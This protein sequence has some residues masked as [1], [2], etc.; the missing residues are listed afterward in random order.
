MK[1]VIVREGTKEFGTYGTLYINGLF[2]CYTLEDADRGL[3]N[4]GTKVAGDTAIPRGVYKVIIDFSKRFNKEMI[5]VLDVP[6]FA[7]VRIHAGN[8]S[9]DTEGCPLVGNGRGTPNLPLL[10]SR[11]A[12][13]KLFEIVDAALEKGDEVTLE[14]K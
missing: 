2:Q 9:H 3:E 10:D 13:N 6:Q 1:L 4:G 14:V 12:A 5:H 11:T 8:T 7:G